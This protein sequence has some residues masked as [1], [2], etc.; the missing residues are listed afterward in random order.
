VSAPEF[1]LKT[2]GEG[3]PLGP[4]RV[5]VEADGMECGTC[6]QK[7]ARFEVI[8]PTDEE[9]DS[10]AFGR[11]EDAQ[12]RADAFNEGWQR[13]RADGMTV[14]AC[15]CPI[16]RHE[17]VGEEGEQ[18][19]NPHH[20]CL[21]TTPAL[22]ALLIAAREGPVVQ[23]ERQPDGVTRFEWR[24]FMVDEEFHEAQHAPD[25]IAA[26]A[27]EMALRLEEAMLEHYKIDRRA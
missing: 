10:M 22:L 17:D 5:E 7:C 6:E 18:C 4:Y 20:E 27:R 9:G 11:R 24:V 15:G 2:D 19:A 21:R 1:V 14:C 8:G 26:K 25:F 3:Q 23:A 16:D 13:G 12:D